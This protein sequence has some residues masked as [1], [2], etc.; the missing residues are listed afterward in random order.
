M[1]RRKQWIAY[2][3]VDSVTYKVWPEFQFTVKGVLLKSELYTIGG[4][5]KE[6][7]LSMLDYALDMIKLSL[8]YRI[9]TS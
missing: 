1:Y 7:A 8:W 3:D 4:K 6:M 5:E 9:E 2:D